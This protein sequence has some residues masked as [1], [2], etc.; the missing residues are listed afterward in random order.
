MLSRLTIV[1]ILTLTTVACVSTRE[2]M[3]GWSSG[4]VGCDPDAIAIS[5]IR[6]PN[7]CG[8]THTWVAQCDGVRYRCMNATAPE[9]CAPNIRCKETATKR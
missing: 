4:E 8:Q 6:S 2:T 5:H 1:L 9:T 3:Q 7:F